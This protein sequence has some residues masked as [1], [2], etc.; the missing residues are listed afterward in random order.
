MIANNINGIIE[1]INSIS[2]GNQ[3]IAGA[4]S[5]WLLGIITYFSRNIPIKVYNLFSKHLTTELQTSS[6]NEVFHNLLKWLEKNGYSAKFR[7]LRLSNGRWGFNNDATTKSVGYGTHLVWYKKIP[8]IIT[9]TKEEGS[10]GDYE[11]ETITLL[12][13]GRNHKIFDELITEISS[14]ELDLDKSKI[15]GYKDG[16]SFIGSQPKRHIDSVFVENSKIDMLETTLKNFEN[17]EE[18]YIKRGIAYQLGILLYG[19]PGTGKSSLIKAI[20]AL[21]NRNICITKF[22]HV[23][24][25]EN[26]LHSLPEDSIVIIEDVDTSLIVNDRNKNDDS[27]ES[28]IVSDLMS[29]SLSDV[30]NAIDG[31]IV[32]HNRILIMTTNHIEKLDDALLRP[33]RVD[34]KL[35]ISYLTTETFV[36]FM[37]NFFDNIEKDLEHIKLIKEDLTGAQ[38][39]EDILMKRS[40]QEILSI[41]TE[42]IG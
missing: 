26:A 34:L 14:D 28:N 17:S 37:N 16:W 15:Y 7:K 39:Q 38:L 5:L 19:P 42:K 11:K 31:V 29:Q 23:S 1:F 8:I 2:G 41:Y 24:N 22:N 36:K 20:A 27:V 21:T 30:L 32:K 3:M 18:W 40:Y 4:I 33:G 35:E 25:L 12:K 6:Q 10:R 13:L 9:F